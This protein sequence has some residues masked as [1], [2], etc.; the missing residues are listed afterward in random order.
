VAGTNGKGSVCAMLD[1]ICRGGGIRCGLYT[2]P[3]LVTFRERI[4]LDGKMIPEADVAAG[5]ARIREVI[6]DWEQPPTFFEVTTALALD[7]F[8]DQHAHVVILETGLGGRLDA[9]NV[10]TPA[11]SVLTPIALDHQQVLGDSVV[12][13][14]AE[15]CGIIKAGIPVVSAPQDEEAAAVILATARKLGSPCEWVTEPWAGEVGLLG[16]HQCWNAALAVHALDTAATQHAF[17]SVKTDAIET[18]L[19]EVRWPGRFEAATDRVILDGAH[20]PAAART[21]VNTYQGEFGTSKATLI[22]G[23]MRD[24]DVRE[25]IHALMPIAARVFTVAIDNPRALSAANLAEVVRSLSPSV[26]VQ[27][28]PSLSVALKAAKRERER[29]LIAGS[30]FL[31]GAALVEL[32]LATPEGERSVQ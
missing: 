32:G 20:N 24:K 29:I 16:N 3:H 30:L 17:L 25:V 19:S 23:I 8:Q 18:A 4:R 27:E 14:A 11:V 2:S 26:A 22:I 7:W 10:V 28:F 5:L 12:Q 1:A 13:I 21:L 9:T 31:V 15:K 6:A